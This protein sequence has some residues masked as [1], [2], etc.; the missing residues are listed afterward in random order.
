MCGR[1]RRGL[2]TGP[3]TGLGL[4]RS[5]RW[6]RRLVWLLY[7]L[8]LRDRWRLLRLRRCIRLRGRHRRCL[9]RRNGGRGKLD[10]GL[11]GLGRHVGL[12]LSDLVVARGGHLVAGS[13]VGDHLRERLR[14]RR[15]RLLVLRRCHRPRRL[16]GLLIRL[17]IWRLVLRLLG[18]NGRP[19]WLR[20]LVHRPLLRW[21]EWRCLLRCIL[22]LRL[23]DRRLL[24]RLL[25]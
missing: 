13:L 23:R 10:I 22:R 25:P 1:L 2:L 15:I 12:V 7:R 6:R 14:L 11:G 4:R 19:L 17:L 18:V 5:C 3:G 20:R 9:N 16:I 24:R 8:R 21:S